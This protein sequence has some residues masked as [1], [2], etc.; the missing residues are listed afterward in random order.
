MKLDTNATIA[1]IHH[2]AEV[3]YGDRLGFY[4]GMSA[5]DALAAET[6]R[7][8]RRMLADDFG[9]D[10]FA[11]VLDCLA[12]EAGVDNVDAILEAAYASVNG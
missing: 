5:A 7:L 11:A 9:D 1:A 12:T 10:Q 8:G 2:T 6:A 4:A 3:A